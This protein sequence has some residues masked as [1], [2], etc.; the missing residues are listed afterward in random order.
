[1][2]T[3]CARDSEGRASRKTPGVG[4]ATT[5]CSCRRIEHD[6]REAVRR[7]LRVIRVRFRVPE[8][9]DLEVGDLTK[10][11][12]Y[13]LLSGRPRPSVHFPRSQVGWDSEGLP[14]LRRL[15]RRHRWELAC[16]LSSL[17][18]GLRQE[19]CPKHRPSS[20]FEKWKE[21]ACQEDPPR[22]SPEYLRFAAKV[23]GEVFKRGWDR[24]YPS[25]CESFVPKDSC[26]FGGVRSGSRWWTENCGRKDFLRGVLHGKY[27]AIEG[28]KLMYSEVPTVGKVRAL[29]V[30]TVDYDLLGPLHKTM[31]HCLSKQDWLLVGSPTVRRVARTC[32]NQWQ[33]SVDLVGAT[34]GLRLDV[35][36]KILG[37]ALSRSTL[38]PGKICHDAFE[39]LRPLACSRS[40]EQRGEFS[41]VTHGQMM[42]TYLSFPLLCLQSYIAARW[43]TRGMDGTRYLVNGD[44]TL[45]SAV[46]P[47]E[48]SMYPEGLELNTMKTSIQ[49]NF[50]EVNSTQFIREGGKWREIVG[51]RRG[52][53]Y[54]G[55]EGTLHMASACVAAGGPWQAAMCSSLGRQAIYRPSELGLSLW[56][57]SVNRLEN[58]MRYVSYQR[59]VRQPNEPSRFIRIPEAPTYGDKV[60]F[61][62]DLWSFGRGKLPRDRKAVSSIFTV[63]P[64]PFSRGRFSGKLSGVRL[65]YRLLER[66]RERKKER[67]QEWCYSDHFDRV[68]SGKLVWEE[69]EEGCSVVYH[70]GWY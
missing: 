38:V 32:V 16:S 8:L 14:V 54:R 25:F 50:A 42:G 15:G 31:Y 34:D 20:G 21:R 46:S 13:L 39:S 19:V 47:V 35:A 22:S 51:L 27:E 41:F 3:S 5:K 65:A 70:P 9:P 30:P 2:A 43:A 1:M 37:V 18:R 29:G 24:S 59:I 36:E 49:M 67:T 44:D 58:R 6:N 23:A 56:H 69:G 52:A 11:L 63:V 60:A 45:I 28:F 68:T 55:L 10:Y 7:S 33:T 53:W 57:P 4:K 48:A 61:W 26:R 17:K 64:P 66:D 40:G 12:S 62:E